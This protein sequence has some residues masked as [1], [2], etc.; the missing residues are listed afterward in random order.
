LFGWLTFSKIA[1]LSQKEKPEGLR[2]TLQAT[3][4]IPV[5]ALGTFWLAMALGILHLR[6]RMTGSDSAGLT[7]LAESQL[8]LPQIL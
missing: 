6:F 1:I 5:F 4:P 8:S 3:G 7:L 2:K